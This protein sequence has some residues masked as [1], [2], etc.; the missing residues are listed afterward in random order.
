M[1][2]HLLGMAKPGRFH[3]STNQRRSKTLRE[4][5]LPRA[6]SHSKPISQ[7]YHGYFSV[8]KVSTK[9]TNHLRLQLQVSTF[10]REESYSKYVGS[11]KKQTLKEAKWFSILFCLLDEIFFPSWTQQLWELRKSEIS[12]IG[13]AS[14]F[15]PLWLHSTGKSLFITH[16]DTCQG[17]SSQ[18]KIIAHGKAI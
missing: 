3:P 2:S 13:Q 12:A 4:A 5:H 6:V 10:P 17:G 14:T 11:C 8:G 16:R 7:I 9:D 18:P 15:G 1:G